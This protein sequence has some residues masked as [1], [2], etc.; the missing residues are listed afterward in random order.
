MIEATPMKRESKEWSVRVPMELTSGVVGWSNTP[1]LGAWANICIRGMSSTAQRTETVEFC[2]ALVYIFLRLDPVRVLSFMAYVHHF[3]YQG[4]EKTKRSCH[5]A[6]F[7]PSVPPCFPPIWNKGGGNSSRNLVDYSFRSEHNKKREE[8]TEMGWIPFIVYIWM[9]VRLCFLFDP[10]GSKFWPK[11]IG[12]II[13]L[14][15][16]P[17]VGYRKQYF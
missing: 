15:Q 10:N 17:S 7:P 11:L 16:I 4:R 8:L 3:L 5:I 12:R 13:I 1:C 14:T 2:T 9:T 6:R